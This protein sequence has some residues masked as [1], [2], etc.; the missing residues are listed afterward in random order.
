MGK[1]PIVLESG[2]EGFYASCISILLVLWVSQHRADG[3]RMV[4]IGAIPVYFVP[5]VRA[6]V[7]G[8]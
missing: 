3:H 1:S 6:R 7:V 8:P 4:Q 5:G 2:L